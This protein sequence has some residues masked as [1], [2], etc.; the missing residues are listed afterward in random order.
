MLA[1]GRKSQRS[2]SVT[3]AWREVSGMI[4]PPMNTGP[5]SRCG[6]A[7]RLII[8]TLFVFFLFSLGFRSENSISLLTCTVA[9]ISDWVI[10]VSWLV[11]VL[12]PLFNQVARI[13]DWVILVPHL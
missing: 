11:I 9:R 2:S 1:K 8:Q 6:L 10:L 7:S 12:S 4:I 5:R 13:S 3:G